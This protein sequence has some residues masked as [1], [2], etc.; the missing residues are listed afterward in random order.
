MVG[1][2]ILTSESVGQNCDKAAAA[3]SV[4]C[5][6][7][8]IYWHLPQKCNASEGGS[9]CSEAKNTRVW[10]CFQSKEFE[11]YKPDRPTAHLWSWEPVIWR[12]AY[13]IYA[14]LQPWYQSKPALILPATRI[15]V[16]LRSVLTFTFSMVILEEAAAGT[17]MRGLNALSPGLGFCFCFIACWCCRSFSLALCLSLSLSAALHHMSCLGTS[18]SE[19][20]RL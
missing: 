7:S 8:P 19:K 18:C 3:M 14:S 6:R 10:H 15:V 5:A 16:G 2:W 9:M 13:N 12:L 17:M 11:S 4:D 20:D 1:W